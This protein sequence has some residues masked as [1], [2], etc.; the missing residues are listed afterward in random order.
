MR[1]FRDRLLTA[2]ALVAGCAEHAGDPSSDPDAGSAS[3]AVGYAA[4]DPVAADGNCLE[5]VVDH[6][7]SRLLPAQVACGLARA[8]YFADPARAQLCAAA[9][10]DPA[11]NY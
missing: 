9:C 4:G 2:V 3:A 10:D 8:K 11:V 1:P 6:Y 5:I 7:D